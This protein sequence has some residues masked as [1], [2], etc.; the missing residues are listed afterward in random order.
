MGAEGAALYAQVQHGT[1]KRSAACAALGAAL[2]SPCTCT[3]P[4]AA[5]ALMHGLCAPTLRASTTRGVG[6]AE[7][8]LVP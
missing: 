2:P 6:L 8:S 5:H 7:E 4:P 1:H 3:E